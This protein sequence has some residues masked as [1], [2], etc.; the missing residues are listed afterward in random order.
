MIVRKRDW[1]KLNGRV[2]RLEELTKV[3]M[4]GS[5]F[6]EVEEVKEPKKEVTKKKGRKPK[7]KVEEKPIP[8]KRG[9]K[10]KKEV[11]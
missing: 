6:V 2:K 10:P 7:T 8:K 9:R 3:L 4:L 1:E 11:K 5:I